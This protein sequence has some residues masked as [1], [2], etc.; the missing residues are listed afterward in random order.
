MTEQFKEDIKEWV[1]LDNLHKKYNMELK[2]LRNKKNSFLEKI[3]LNVN[4]LNLSNSIVKISDGR[5]KF[6]NTKYTK[7]LTLSYIKSTLQ[8]TLKDTEHVDEIIMLLRVNREYILTDDIK[9]YYD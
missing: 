7:P 9:R 5:L 4:N 2:E 3:N 6:T 8:R 1:K